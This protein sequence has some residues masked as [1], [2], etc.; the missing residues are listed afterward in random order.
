MNT[1]NKIMRHYNSRQAQSGHSHLTLG[2]AEYTTIQ[3]VPGERTI[4]KCHT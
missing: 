2:N 4:M 3:E 1:M